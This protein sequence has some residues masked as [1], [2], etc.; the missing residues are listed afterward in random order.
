MNAGIESIDVHGLNVY[1]AKIK[2][3]SALKKA[4]KSVYRLRI[5]HGFNHGTAIRDM[6]AEEYLNHPKVRKIVTGNNFGQTEFIL[7]DF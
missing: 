5:I 7:R 1:Q 6:I 3:D 4:D 2:I